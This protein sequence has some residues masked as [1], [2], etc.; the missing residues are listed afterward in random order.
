MDPF[1]KRMYFESSQILTSLETAE[2]FFSAR[3]H[4]KRRVFRYVV[5]ASL[6]TGFF[7]LYFPYP[8]LG[9]LIVSYWTTYFFSTN[10]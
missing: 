9:V 6:I 1:M 4:A 3:E 2:R 10:S 8:P 5:A 7:M